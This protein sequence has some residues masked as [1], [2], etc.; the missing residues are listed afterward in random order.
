VL[1]KLQL[2]TGAGAVFADP[3][4]PLAPPL[5]QPEEDEDGDGDAAAAGPG[6]G[7]D[8]EGCAFDGAAAGD[9]AGP[10]GAF[11]AAA[12]APP[13]PAA[14]RGAPARPLPP[15]AAAG[16]EPVS[17]RGLLGYALMD[18]KKTYLMTGMLEEALGMVRWES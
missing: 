2:P 5:L 10:A 12:S 14:W 13:R 11:A 15:S 7:L 1:L 16:L 3:C 8:G 4:D 17:L 6:C 9:A 18:V